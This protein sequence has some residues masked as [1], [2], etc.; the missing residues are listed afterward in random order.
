MYFS[1]AF[2]RRPVF[3]QVQWGL[4]RVS[5]ETGAQFEDTESGYAMSLDVPGLAK[6]QL[7]IEIDQRIVRINAVDDAPRSFSAAYRLPTPLDAEASTAKLEN[8]VL[9]LNLI[10]LAPVV[11]ARAVAIA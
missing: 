11:T 1:P 6:E 3:A 8:G 2:V 7:R 5:S 4:P 10:K 9:S